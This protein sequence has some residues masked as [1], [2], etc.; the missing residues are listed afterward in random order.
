VSDFAA[1][2]TLEEFFSPPVGRCI[3]QGSH[4]ASFDRFFPRET[5][6][7]VDDD[8][9]VPEAL[10]KTWGQRGP[11]ATSRPS[12]QQKNGNQVKSSSR[13]PTLQMSEG[14]RVGGVTHSSTGV[15]ESCENWGAVPMWVH[16]RA[17][18]CVRGAGRVVR[19]QP[20][21]LQTERGLA[22]RENLR[23]LWVPTKNVS[24]RATHTAA[25]ASL[26][27]YLFPVLGTHLPRTSHA[28]NTLYGYCSQG[29]LRVGGA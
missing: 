1:T 17:L 23:E 15:R 28:P 27:F 19:E 2:E 8:Q 14:G 12:F 13:N 5:G 25:G 16:V 11:Q 10:D 24:S 29:S 20:S 26:F 6:L 9:H 4:V 22:E 18:F 7:V 3:G 21:G